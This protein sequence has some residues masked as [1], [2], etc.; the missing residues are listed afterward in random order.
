MNEFFEI[1][2]FKKVDFIFPF[3]NDET[4]YKKDNK[5]GLLSK[6]GKFITSNIFD[7]ILWKSSSYYF[8][9]RDGKYN[10]YSLDD[11]KLFY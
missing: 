3:T 9:K 8:V 5:Y 10:Y 2:F 1:L 11:K 6:K 7:E 4:I